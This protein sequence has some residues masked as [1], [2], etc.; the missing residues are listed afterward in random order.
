MTIIAAME[1]ELAGLRRAL[2]QSGPANP[3]AAREFGRPTPGATELQVELHAVGVGR[4]PAQAAVTKLLAEGRRAGGNHTDA[5]LLLGFAGGLNPGLRSGDLCLPSHFIRE[6]G[7]VAD[8]G[9]AADAGPVADAHPLEPD[10]AMRQQAAGVLVDAGLAWSA[11]DSLTVTE[12]VATPEAKA[13]RFRQYRAGV[14]DMEDYW[15]ADLAARQGMPF[16]AVRAVLDP[17]QQGLPP[18]VLGL[19]SRDRDRGRV[20]VTC[21]ARP[22]RVAGLLRLSRQAGLAQQ[23]LAHFALAFI[24]QRLA[25]SGRPL[26]AA[27]R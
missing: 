3:K 17:A 5:L 20:V 6:D 13:E 4:E 10:A 9:P 8:A 19:A 26:T 14:V 16:L 27:Q 11:G 23:S 24:R 7:P 2:R 22:W 15:F 12:L 25:E 18:Y 1:Y 21:A